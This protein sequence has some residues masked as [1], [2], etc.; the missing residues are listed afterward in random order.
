VAVLVLLGILSAVGMQRLVPTNTLRLQSH[1][2]QVVAAFRA[3][4]QRAMIQGDPVRLLTTA[5]SLDVRQDADGDGTFTSSESLT[6]GGVIYPLD[7][8]GNQTLSVGQF[9]F[10]RLGRTA[11]GTITMT[12][13]SDSVTVDVASTGY[14]D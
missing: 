1:R 5:T 13:G 4:Q 10:D 2:D 3:A 8:P 11:A 7:L 12:L 9:D 6:L 14:V